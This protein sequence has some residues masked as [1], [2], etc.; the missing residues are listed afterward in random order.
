MRVACTIWLT[1]TTNRNALIHR[2]G[3]A[4]SSDRAR[5][6]LDALVEA[7]REKLERIE[8]LIEDAEPDPGAS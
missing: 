5:A 1:S 6:G 3:A 8:S 7:V 4:T 2:S